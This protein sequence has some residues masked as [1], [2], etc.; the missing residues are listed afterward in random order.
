LKLLIALLV[1]MGV[2]CTTVSYAKTD[3]SS[4]KTTKSTKKT[5]GEEKYKKLSQQ[6]LAL[7]K[8]VDQAKYDEL[9]KITS[10]KAQ[11]KAC[12]EYTKSYTL[13]YLQK[14]D[15]A[16]YKKL[17]QLRKTNVKLYRNLL[18]SEIS[19]VFKEAQSKAAK[20]DA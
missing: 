16:K 13:S 19:R 3:S 7:I 1:A 6:Y 18:K 5:S 15:P 10:A 11:Y 12:M 4:T 14:N 20:S 9:S 8:L 17:E 2:T